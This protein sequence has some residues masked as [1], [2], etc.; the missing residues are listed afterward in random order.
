[1]ARN[2]GSITKRIRSMTAQTGFFKRREDYNIWLNK[3]Y[4][5]QNLLVWNSVSPSVQVIYYLFFW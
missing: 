2:R 1:M 5:Q 4:G 3:Y